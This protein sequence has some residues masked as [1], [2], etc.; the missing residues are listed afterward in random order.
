LGIEY[1]KPKKKILSFLASNNYQN[2]NKNKNNFIF[3]F[4]I[5][6][7]IRTGQEGGERGGGEGMGGNDI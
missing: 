2:K 6:L 1:Q 5:Y 3:Y 4:F 7:N